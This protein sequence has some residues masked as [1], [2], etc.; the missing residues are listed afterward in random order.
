MM[1]RIIFSIFFINTNP[2]L[3]TKTY[4]THGRIIY[5]FSII[6]ISI[7]DSFFRYAKMSMEANIL[8][9]RCMSSIMLGIMFE[10]KILMLCLYMFRIPVTTR[11]MAKKKKKKRLIIK[12]IR[13][14]I[15]NLK[16][17]AVVINLI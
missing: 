15:A 17:I 8:I 3:I 12:R 16:S 1:D 6:Y 13:S 5:R 11:L 10:N 4:S 14:G 2:T 7:R 9:T